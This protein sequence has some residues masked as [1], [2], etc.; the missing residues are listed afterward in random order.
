MIYMRHI[1]FKI[2]KFIRGRI[3]PVALALLAFNSVA[4]DHQGFSD[5]SQQLKQARNELAVLL[6]KYTELH[7]EV[8]RVKNQIKQLE[9]ET[10]LNSKDFGETPPL[11]SAPENKPA[12]AN[13]NSLPL[14]IAT[15][16]NPAEIKINTALAFQTMDGFGSTVRLFDDPHFSNTWNPQTKR[17]SALLTKT[18]EDE[19]L[20]LAYR[21][22]GLSRV[23]PATDAGIEVANDNSDPN[24]TDL[25]KL[26]FSWKRNDG[27]I[28]Y[29]KRVIPLGVHTYF[30]SPVVV[31][32]WMNESNP[33]EYVEWAYQIIKRWRDE[34]IELPYYSI[35]NEPNYS[36]E[37]LQKV[38]ILLGRKLKEHGL[39]TKLVIPDA[40]NPDSAYH[41]SSFILAEPE[42]RQYIGAL[43]YHMYGSQDAKGMA[44][45]AAKYN[46]PLWMTE[47]SQAN[48]IL[49][50]ASLMHR[51]I[52]E[53]N[54]SAIDYMWSFFGDWSELKWPGDSLISVIFQYNVYKGYRINP[55]YY[56][57]KHYSR[58]IRPGFNRVHATSTNSGLSV[59]AFAKSNELVVVILNRT[60][61]A[62]TGRLSMATNNDLP[63]LDAIQSWNNHYWKQPPPAIKKSQELELSLPPQSVTTLFTPPS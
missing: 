32:S 39:K 38:T 63:A 43:A 58:Y 24:D 47:F 16:Q 40:I 18:Q 17:A 42:A 28:D 10:P 9:S 46:I 20:T 44:E 34:G 48:N 33:Q 13:P 5:N 12:Q 45:L 57:I 23:R 21:D 62:I 2:T 49:D 52:T 25:T 35:K 41:Y 59:S 7:P 27:Y 8:I 60:D 61:Q 54:V 30:L 51:Q 14:V 56:A 29:I 1:G 15:G 6:Q 36:K 22:L 31:E 3:A 19:I 37:Y 53:Y 4:A 26:D 11:L 50:W 55:N